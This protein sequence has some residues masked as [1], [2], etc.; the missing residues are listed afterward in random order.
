MFIGAA[1]I[2]WLSAAAVASLLSSRAK[3]P[4]RPCCSAQSATRWKG[5][6]ARLL[7]WANCTGGCASGVPRHSTQRQLSAR[8]L[9]QQIGGR[10]LSPVVS[11][12][13]SCDSVSQAQPTGGILPA[14]SAAGIAYGS[15]TF[16]TIHGVIVTAPGADVGAFSRAGQAYFYQYLGET[17]G[18]SFVLSNFGTFTT[19]FQSDVPG[20]NYRF[21]E[22][23]SKSVDGRLVAIVESSPGRIHVLHA[24]V[25]QAAFV[26]SSF[27]LPT[28]A[29]VLTSGNPIAVAESRLAVA[30]SY[31]GLTPNRRIVLFKV[32]AETGTWVSASVANDAA[33]LDN[34][35]AWVALFDE[36]MAIGLPERSTEAGGV[37]L[38][39]SDESGGWARVALLSEPSAVASPRFGHAVA[40]GQAAGDDDRVILVAG[41]RRLVLDS[42]ATDNPCD[43]ALR[44][45]SAA[46][47]KF[48]ADVFFLETVTGF[49]ENDLTLSGLDCQSPADN[50]P[51]FAFSCT[52]DGSQSTVSVR[53]SRQASIVPSTSGHS[54]LTATFT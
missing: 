43:M 51:A 35:W 10:G 11:R 2:V 9:S 17:A 19:V 53:I 13:H 21:G 12:T 42:S 54:V 6:G 4:I 46:R 7:A 3:D 30:C 33:L 40:L 39:K 50:N 37:L 27:D 31:D 14:S 23:A 48:I 36:F 49:D 45:L 44:V 8:L 24:H 18:N 1:V 22:I 34:D 38:L 16:A 5:E 52:A 47:G 25:A 41:S 28:G 26:Q 20:D 32:D 15:K 29:A